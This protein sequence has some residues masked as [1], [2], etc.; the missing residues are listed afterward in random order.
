MDGQDPELH[1]WCLKPMVNPGRR[2]GEGS[3]CQI[4]K[5]RMNPGGADGVLLGSDESSFGLRFPAQSYPFPSFSSCCICLAW[6]AVSHG[7]VK[8]PRPALYLA[9]DCSNRVFVVR[10]QKNASWA[11]CHPSPRQ[12]GYPPG[13]FLKAGSFLLSKVIIS[14]ES[15]LTSKIKTLQDY[16][17]SCAE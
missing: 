8:S 6:V 1:L 11:N 16:L 4:E 17:P 13:S 7:S 14:L 12:S 9:L 10:D 3:C 15:F 5:Q 2:R